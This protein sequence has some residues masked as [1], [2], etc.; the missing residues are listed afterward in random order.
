MRM[1]WNNLTLADADG[2][3]YKIYL[4]EGTHTIRLEATLGGSGILLEELEDS[5]Y[6]SESDLQETFGYI[7][8]QRRI[9]TA[10]TILIRY[11]RK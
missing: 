5:I 11:I 7:P 6:L 10:I 9:N 2:N 3:P 1:T 8:E 4:T